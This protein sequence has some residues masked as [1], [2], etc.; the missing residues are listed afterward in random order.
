M[1]IAAEIAA[2]LAEA[3]S[4]TGD[5][6]LY[7]TIKR[8]G[9]PASR[10]SEAEASGDGAPSFY[11]VVAVQDTRRLRDQSGMLTGQVAT[12]LAIE[13]TGVAPLKS[14]LIAVGVRVA[15]VDGQTNFHEVSAVVTTAP[16]GVPVLYEVTLAG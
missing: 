11:E 6:P 10:P 8:S 12:V 15:D 4:A 5:G 7:C 9:A 3:G 14:D 13:A 1:T 2:A 16:G